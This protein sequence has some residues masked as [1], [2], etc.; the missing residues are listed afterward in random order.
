[1]RRPSV[2]MLAGTAL[3][4]VASVLLAQPGALVVPPDRAMLLVR[5]PADAKVT[6]GD[7]PTQQTGTERVFTTPSLQAGYTYSYEVGATWKDGGKDRTVRRTIVFQRGQFKTVDLTQPETDTKS[8]TK[9]DKKKE[10]EKKLDLPSFAGTLQSVEVEK[11]SFTIMQDGGAMR[12]FIVNESTK[13]VGGRGGSRGIGKPALKDEA[14]VK[15]TAVL[16]V[17]TPDSQAALEVHLP[18]RKTPLKDGGKK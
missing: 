8:E 18:P 3:L 11:A 16:V 9:T 5:V 12:T 7:Q 17:A 4:F 1:M 6:I 15:G 2:L 10:P 13:F 14:M